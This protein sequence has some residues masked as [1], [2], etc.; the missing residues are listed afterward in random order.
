LS[1]VGLLERVVTDREAGALDIPVDRLIDRC[2]TLYV[3]L[4]GAVARE[5]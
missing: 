5:R 1:L 3:K 2:V 4:L